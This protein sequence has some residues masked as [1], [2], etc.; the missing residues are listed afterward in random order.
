MGAATLTGWVSQVITAA[1]G[2]EA[3]KI[4][5]EKDGPRLA[6]VDWMMPRL[7]GVALCQRLRSAAV[8]P[9]LYV[10]LLTAKEGKDNIITALEAGA[11]DFI[12]KPFDHMELRARLRVG[13]RIVGLQERLAS[14]VDD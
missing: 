10:I 7:D 1:D 14:K 2:E 5:Q 8:V 12:S 6:I 4:L 3:W 9:P 11:D 13:L